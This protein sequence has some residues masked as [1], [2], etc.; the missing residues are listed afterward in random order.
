TRKTPAS[1]TRESRSARPRPAP[2]RSTP[3][4][5]TPCRPAQ[6]PPTPTGSGG[7]PTPW[8]PEAPSRTP[9]HTTPDQRPAR[10]P[11]RR[12][13]D[14]GWGAQQRRHPLPHHSLPVGL[15]DPVIGV[16][17][18]LGH[19]TRNEV[20]H[21]AQVRLSPP[22][23]GRTHTQNVLLRQRQELPVRALPRT[24]RGSCPYPLLEPRPDAHATPSGYTTIRPPP[25]SSYALR[26]TGLRFRAR[27]RAMI[28]AT[29]PSIL[30]PECF[31]SGLTLSEASV[32]TAKLSTCHRITGLP[33][34]RS[35]GRLVVPCLS[36][37]DN[38]FNGGDMDT[39]P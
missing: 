31:L 13:S 16:Q 19:V 21:G 33:P 36:S 14:Q 5:R 4:A 26:R 18:E 9:G 11:A 23:L 27:S 17:P 38:S 32:A 12:W 37:R 29:T 34:C 2:A 6:P 20:H 24:P 25:S 7:S 1:A 3:Q 39:K 15:G 10:R 30:S 35:S 28:S 22:Q 8:P